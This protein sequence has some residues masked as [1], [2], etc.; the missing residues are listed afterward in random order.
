M[1]L[2]LI[3]FSITPGERKKEAIHVRIRGKGLFSWARQRSLLAAKG[4]KKRKNP[5]LLKKRKGEN[6]LANM[7]DDRQSLF[8]EEEEGKRGKRPLHQ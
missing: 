7:I 8:R 3:V 5:V 2:C 4:K 6:A 1:I